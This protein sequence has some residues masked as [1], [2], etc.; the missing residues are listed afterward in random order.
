[1]NIIKLVGLEVEGGWNGKPFVPPFEALA[2]TY[3]H[4]I[5]GT[6]MPTDKRLVCQHI[7]EAISPPIEV[8]KVADWIEKYWPQHTNITCGYHIHLS[9]HSPLHYMLLTKKSYAIRLKKAME[10]LARERNLPPEHYIWHRLSGRNP[11]CN[12]DFDSAGQ[13]SVTQKRVG[14]RVR[15][16]FL[17]FALN[18]HGTME[19]RALP[20]FDNTDD[21]RAFTFHFFNVTEQYVQDEVANIRNLKRSLSLTE[22]MGS[23]EILRTKGVA[24]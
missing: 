24:K 23:H 3:D 16:G 11:F 5:D 15:Y 13:M 7:G 22:V 1:V 18:I 4:S 17:N 19:F 21:A 9:F 2:L 8:D 12:M 14:M 20:T 6:T 10:N